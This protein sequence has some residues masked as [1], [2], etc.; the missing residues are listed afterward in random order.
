[1][2][3]WKAWASFPYANFARAGVKIHEFALAAVVLITGAPSPGH[4]LSV[5][6]DARNASQGEYSVELRLADGTVAATL[7]QTTGGPIDDI[8]PDGRGGWFV[9]GWFD[10]VGDVACP[11]L[12]HLLPSGQLDTSWC[13]RPD[14]G[15]DQIA[16]DG[17]RL[18]VTGSFHNIAGVDRAY[19]AAFDLTTWSLTPWRVLR[20]SARSADALAANAGRVVVGSELGE[21]RAMVLA[22]DARTGRPLP[23]RVTF[24]NACVPKD[25]EC[26]ARIGAI[27]VRGTR[28]YVAGHFKHV[29]DR[30]HFG[31]V[32]LDAR[33]GRV[34][35]WTANVDR[36]AVDPF[37]L[38]SFRWNL[39][40]FGKTVYVSGGF[41]RVNG[42][43]RPQIAALEARTGRVRAW[44]PQV[45]AGL[46]AVDGFAVT[47]SAVVL[48]YDY[49]NDPNLDSV[50]LAVRR[51]DRAYG[52]NIRWT[53][54]GP[55]QVE[56]TAP[57]ILFVGLSGGNVL[58]QYFSGMS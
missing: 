4:A 29:Q 38:D 46:L 49:A 40:A 42:I 28:V 35:P 39:A 13:P 10:S 24:D 11:Y 31:L 3:R 26:T 48:A 27:L 22:Y 5:L 56:A 16:R 9:A 52:R 58:V 15:I 34:L 17:T 32:A 2:R 54:R 23:W 30:R 14:E 20:G 47:S 25:R 19:Y 45:P 37:T 33:N 57:L 8:E 43:Q 12:V 36:E 21:K 55:W 51:V 50:G 1:V 7:P 18:Y 6:P 53:Y 44:K 41:W